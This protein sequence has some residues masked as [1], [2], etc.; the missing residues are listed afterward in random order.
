MVFVPRH[1]HRTKTGLDLVGVALVTV[2]AVLVIYPLVQGRE[3][4]WPWWC[5][6]MIAGG[7]L[8]FGAFIGYE[9]ATGRAPVIEASLLSNRTFSAGLAV[10]LVFFAAVGGFL[11]AFGLYVQLGL[12]FTPL[13]A[14]LTALPLSVGI[15]L[16][17][18]ASRWLTPRLGRRLLH[19]G[20]LIVTL[21]LVALAATTAHF[22]LSMTT[23]DVT[24]AALIT[25]LGMGLVF[26]PLF[27]VILG[28]VGD[29]EVGSA[30]G[31]L[32]AVQQLGGALGV[33]GITTL[34]F[35]LAGHTHDT[36]AA[37]TT[38]LAAAGATIIAFG[39][40]FLLPKQTRSNR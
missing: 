12:R 4:G 10:A 13:H 24:P 36:T 9:R 26:G 30:S 27:G 21:G 15:L 3:L 19:G 16:A 34:Y 40:V 14:G 18:T 32:S 33:A 29:S 7:L 37:T 5:F 17:A 11:F 38:A 23:W 1:Q 8:V 2:A 25:G 31:T 6:A 20:L 39:L 35:A 28:A 22:R